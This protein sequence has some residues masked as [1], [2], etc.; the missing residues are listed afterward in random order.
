MLEAQL[1]GKLPLKYERLEDLLTS[2]VFGCLKYIPYKDGLHLILENS[3]D[4]GNKKPTILADNFKVTYRFWPQ[5]KED[6]YC[7][8]CEPDVLVTFSTE[9]KIVMQLLIEAK[10]LSEKS[11]E[12][13]TEKKCNDQLAKEW[14]N[15]SKLTSVNGAEPLLLYIT[16]ELYYPKKNIDDSIKEFTDKWKRTDKEQT[17]KKP[18]HVYWISWK[19]LPKIFSSSSNEIIADLVRLLR[20]QGLTFF[21]GLTAPSNKFSDWKFTE[22]LEWK[23]S[24]KPNFSKWTFNNKA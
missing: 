20:S 8:G 4:E 16:N 14:E 7:K 18:M 21:E 22:T 13:N 9:G 23:W 2:N 3:V 6:D 10:Y 15:L 24:T 1:N 19:E 12:A 17:W 11:S 5:M